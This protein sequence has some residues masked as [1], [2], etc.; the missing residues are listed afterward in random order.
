MRPPAARGAARR[1][2]ALVAMV[3]TLAL[4]TACTVGP[5]QRPPVAVRGDNMPAQA[6]AA[7]SAPSGPRPLP[8]PQPGVSTI[9]YTDCTAEVLSVL[10]IPVAPDR[11]LR[12]DCGTL[13]V[14]LDPEQPAEATTQ[15][16]VIRAGAGPRDPQRPPLA[17]VGDSAAEPS[18][19]IAAVL[20]G[21]VPP[22]LLN[23]FDLVAIDRRGSGFDSLQCAP[24]SARAALVDAD[25]GAI[26]EPSLGRLLDRA[27]ELVQQ[28]TIDED[29]NLATFRSATTALDLETLRD[30]LGVRQLSALGIGDGAAAV[31]GWAR[32]EPDAAGRIVLDG[33]PQ[34]G[35]DDPDLTDTRIRATEA[36]FDAFA[37]SCAARPDCPLGADPR[38]TVAGL[39]QRLQARPLASIGGDRLTAGTALYALRIGLIEPRGWPTLAAAVAA[40]NAGDPAPLLAGLDR[41]LGPRGTFD[42]SLATTCN[43]TTRRLAPGQAAE[44]AARMRDTYPLFGAAM[45]LQVVVCA[46]WPTGRTPAPDTGAGLPP[47]LVVGAAADPR[48]TLDGARRLAQ[49]LPGAVFVSWQGAGTGAFPRTACVSDVV[50]RMLVDGVLP[51]DGT[52]CPP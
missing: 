28:C 21:Q 1:G 31:L 32:A 36:A 51:A 11:Q 41:V 35:L 49:S 14:P 18:A 38:T 15:L 37:A 17:V 27:R 46:P 20:A 26:D 50:T 34:P 48:S 52:L 23:R 9:D 6:P 24:P 13:E 19:L 42:G 16:Q 12:L 5:S 22:D 29:G 3:S 40:A 30:A 8:E 33:P 43:D 39:V 45:A 4:L 47:L 2:A 44:F 7:P 25:P 10:Q